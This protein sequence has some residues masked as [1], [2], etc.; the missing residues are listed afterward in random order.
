MVVFM[1]IYTFL[2]INRLINLVLS[3]L[4]ISIDFLFEFVDIFRMRPTLWRHYSFQLVFRNVMYYCTAFR[5]YWHKLPIFH[6]DIWTITHLLRNSRGFYLWRM[7]RITLILSAGQEILRMPK[8]GMLGLLCWNL[9]KFCIS[10][11]IS[12]TWCS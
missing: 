2:Y 4:N 12:A 7:C 10:N 1:I 5:H 3:S 11:L 8:S 9:P 6:I